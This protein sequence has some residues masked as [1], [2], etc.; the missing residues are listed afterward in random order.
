MNFDEESMGHKDQQLLQSV[1]NKNQP[2]IPQ[3]DEAAEKDEDDAKS[4]KS[5]ERKKSEIKSESID[6][7][8]QEEEIVDGSE[9]A[10]ASSKL[11][12]SFPVQEESVNLPDDK[13]IVES[14]KS[15]D[16][17]INLDAAETFRSNK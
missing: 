9:S 1:S 14:T 15:V 6:E 16:W 10:F 7:S 5:F 17:Q 2:S 13:E 3:V 8:Y 11:Q 12:N 4:A